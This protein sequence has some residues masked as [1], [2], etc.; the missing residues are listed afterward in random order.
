M[1]VRSVVR[2]NPLFIKR[3]QSFLLAPANDHRLFLRSD[4]YKLNLIAWSYSTASAVLQVFLAV[5]QA[6]GTKAV[7]FRCRLVEACFEASRHRKE[8]EGAALASPQWFFWFLSEYE[9]LNHRNGFSGFCLNM[10]PWIT[11]MA[12]LVFVWIWALA[13][14][15]LFFW[16]Y[17]SPCITARAF[18]VFVRKGIRV[19]RE[20]LAQPLRSLRLGERENTQSTEW[21]CWAISVIQPRKLEYLY[22][23]ERT[24]FYVNIIHNSHFIYRPILLPHF[25][26]VTKAIVSGCETGH[27]ATRN[28]PFEAAKRPVLA[29]ETI[30]REEGVKKFQNISLFLEQKERKIMGK[31]FGDKKRISYL[32]RLHII[33]VDWIWRQ[34]EMVCKHAEPRWL[35]P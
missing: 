9:P 7:S 15:Q 21:G 4:D 13:S 17:L 14:Q 6:W 24:I 16:F 3:Q 19:V 34:D 20:S 11:A 18:L 29:C 26:L 31:E 8:T 12:F 5:M 10:S 1:A 23:W 30:C 32:C 27:L 35:A 28:G 25:Q 22:S 33:G 2:P